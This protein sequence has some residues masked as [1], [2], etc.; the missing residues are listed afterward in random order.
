M[1]IIHGGHHKMNKGT[2]FTISELAAEFGITPRTI[3][4]YEEVGLLKSTRESLNHHRLYDAR[5][6]ARLK[7]ILRGK[8]FGFSLAEI[9]EM[10]ELYDI[11]P[12]QKEQLTRTIA[13]GQKK[14]T[15]INEMVNELLQLKEE[16]L[17]FTATFI[18]KLEALE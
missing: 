4:Y 8:R 14:I 3:R 10:I 16:M 18:K 1:I 5:T 6:R 15:E 13:L 12:T 2:L 9:K 7:L 17:E 11:D